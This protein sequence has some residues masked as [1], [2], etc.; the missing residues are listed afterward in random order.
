MLMYK[1]GIKSCMHRNKYMF[2]TLNTYTAYIFIIIIKQFIGVT[3]KVK[4][5]D[6]ELHLYISVADFKAHTL[7]DMLSCTLTP[8]QASL[9]STVNCSEKQQQRNTRG[10]SCNVSIMHASSG[11]K[12]ESYRNTF[13]IIYIFF[14]FPLIN[15]P[16]ING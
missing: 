12:L 1:N 4:I 11:R 2:K 14:I 5:T 7:D 15:N 6:R 8:L 16:R 9:L 3:Y 13:V 10:E